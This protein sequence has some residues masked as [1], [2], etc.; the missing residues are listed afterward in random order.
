MVIFP[1][2]GCWKVTGTVGR[3]SLSFVTF[4]LKR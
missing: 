4:V 2:E 1:T 3:A